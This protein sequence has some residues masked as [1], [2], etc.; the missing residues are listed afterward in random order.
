MEQL[1]FK[2][3][4]NTYKELVTKYGEEAVNEMVIYIGNDDELNG[5]HR[6]WYCEMDN[7]ENP[8]D[9]DLFTTD[10]FEEAKGKIILI[11]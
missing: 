8:E 3:I 5:V 7:R 2:E 11:S 6:A 9:A 10:G 1:K 4:I